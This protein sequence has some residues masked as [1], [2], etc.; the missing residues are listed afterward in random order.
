MHSRIGKSSLSASAALAL[1][2]GIE[3]PAAVAEPET[4]A[5]SR[6]GAVE[7]LVGSFSSSDADLTLIGLSARGGMLVHPSLGF[8]LRA[9]LAHARGDGAS[10][11]TLGNITG[12]A[13]YI[14]YRGLGELPMHAY[15]TGS[16]NAP[17]A[18][19]GGE[20]ATAASAFTAF[21][22]PEPGLY[23]PDA[24]SA[25]L[26]GTLLGGD[27][28]KFFE[29]ELDAQHLFVKESAGEDATRVRLR[30]AGGWAFGRRV[31]VF[32]TLT[33]VW[34]ANAASGQDRFLHLVEA[35]VVISGQAGGQA[36]LS[37][38]V[39]LDESYRDALGAFGALFA[40][41]GTF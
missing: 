11:T 30:A 40:M 5:S 41:A 16:I 25:R 24:T 29:G 15:L 21:W 9:P 19:S 26:S 20:G 22:I 10:G 8:G 39:P 37:G 2:V 6:W 34:N 17:T 36:R 23:H 31:G 28:R 38:Y 32:G 4:A 35:G 33:N 13:F 7:L 18:S 3:S 1:A 27:T 14:V 12:D